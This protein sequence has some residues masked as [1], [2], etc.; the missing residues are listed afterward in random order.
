MLVC[1]VCDNPLNITSMTLMLPTLL[2][3]RVARDVDLCGPCERCLDRRIQDGQP[4]E[5]ALAALEGDARRER[6]MAG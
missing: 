6:R 1:D 5:A 4:V 2:G 3:D